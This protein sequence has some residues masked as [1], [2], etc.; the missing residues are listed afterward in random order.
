M[1]DIINWILIGLAILGSIYLVLATIM[2]IIW[3]RDD[4]DLYH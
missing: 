3:P 4:N 2:F 1:T